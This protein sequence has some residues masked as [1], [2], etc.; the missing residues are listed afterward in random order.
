[1]SLNIL[2]KRCFRN[3]VRSLLQGKSVIYLIN[4]YYGTFKLFSGFF[5]VINNTVV[6]ITVQK[7]KCIFSI[8]SLNTFLEMELL[9]Q[10]I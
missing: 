6:N 9:D 8:I 1:M 3:C 7:I 5:T 10:R 2:P 4:L